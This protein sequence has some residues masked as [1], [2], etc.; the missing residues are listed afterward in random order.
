MSGAPGTEGGARRRCDLSAPPGP[1]L[2]ARERSL[3]AAC[4]FWR[5]RFSAPRMHLLAPRALGARKV[6]C[7]G[8][9]LRRS[10]SHRDATIARSAAH[11]PSTSRIE[12]EAALNP[13]GLEKKFTARKPA[14]FSC[15]TWR[16][17]DRASRAL[18]RS[19]PRSSLGELSP[20]SARR[21]RAHLSLIHI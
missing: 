8:H 3:L 1:A 14:R 7:T 4:P 10:E 16:L 21:P 11:N 12:S 6:A 18:L 2:S 17:R 9:C 5:T 20:T 15:L 19:A 13:S